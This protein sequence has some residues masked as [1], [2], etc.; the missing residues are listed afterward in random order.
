MD[1]SGPLVCRSRVVQLADEAATDAQ[2]FDT[3]KD[4]R[5][6]ARWLRAAELYEV[7]ARA[8]PRDGLPFTRRMLATAAHECLC[9]GG[10]PNR[11][12]AFWAELYPQPT[13]DERAAQE[14]HALYRQLAP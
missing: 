4:G 14:R 11:A 8:V 5:A 3:L 13:D 2:H 12:A 7:A 10:E 6:I 9:Q 1:T